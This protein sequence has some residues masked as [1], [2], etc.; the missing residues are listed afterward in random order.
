[1]PP[2]INIVGYTGQVLQIEFR[3]RVTEMICSLRPIIQIKWD[4]HKFTLSINNWLSLHGRLKLAYAGLQTGADPGKSERVGGWGGGGARREGLYTLVTF[5][6]ISVE[7]ECRWCKLLWGSGT[8]PAPF[9]KCERM[10]C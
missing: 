1:M 9:R 2:S 7:G 4:I 3:L 8:T 6:A 5:N 10:I